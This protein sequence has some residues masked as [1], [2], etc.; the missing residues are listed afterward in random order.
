MST[1][2]LTKAGW[3]YISTHPGLRPNVASRSTRIHYF[4][5]MDD[6][7]LCGAVLEA[8]YM[9]DIRLAEEEDVCKLCI[10]KFKEIFV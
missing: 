7:T 3:G 10:G 6:Q 4:I 5:G 8:P 9:S 2:K 1:L